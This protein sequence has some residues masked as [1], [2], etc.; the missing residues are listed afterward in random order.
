EGKTQHPVL[1]DTTNI[2]WPICAGY[3]EYLMKEH[4]K[5][6]YS[7]LEVECESCDNTI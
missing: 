1:Q 6:L 4:D 2:K 7:W 5:A 3:N